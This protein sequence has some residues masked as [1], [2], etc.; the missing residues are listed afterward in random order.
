[1]CHESKSNSPRANDNAR[2]S[3]QTGFTLIELLVVIAII[4]ILIAL[5]LPAVQQAREAAR[6]SQCK[7]NL[8]QFGLALHNY[9]D[10]HSVFPMG[11]T[12]D[13][14]HSDWW[15]Y[16]GVGWGARILPFI[17]QAPLFNKIDFNKQQPGFQNTAA[18]SVELSIFRCPSDPG[19]RVSSSYGP[20][21]YI[22]CSGSSA[23][24][25]AWG[26]GGTGA[27][28]GRS[29][30]YANSKT[31]FRDITDG[32]SNTMVLSECLVGKRHESSQ[33]YDNTLLLTCG[34]NK[35][36]TGTDL[37]ESGSYRGASW[38]TMYNDRGGSFAYTTHFPPNGLRNINS[39]SR[40]LSAYNADAQS[41]HVGGAHVLMGDGAVRFVSENIHLPTWQYLGDK[42]DGN[43]LG[44]F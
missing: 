2:C 41:Q 9:N 22:V 30:M 24:Q 5:L 21:S 39:C 15:S 3:R 16:T 8:K 27:N 17:D 6:R 4:A 19:Q 23:S 32:T 7:N 35:V 29:V 33:T 37:S 1:M 44:E 40:S 42:A 20:T 25:A 18:S 14:A 13:T 12:Y 11:L 31:D 36:Y 28:T 38:F 43:V 10:T 34:E 26:G